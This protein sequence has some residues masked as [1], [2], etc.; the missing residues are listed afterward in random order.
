ML[1]YLV[2]TTFQESRLKDSRVCFPC[3]DSLSPFWLLPPA[4]KI[5][6]FSKKIVVIRRTRCDQLNWKWD[7]AYKMQFM[8]ECQRMHK[9]ER[10]GE[11]LTEYKRAAYRMM[12]TSFMWRDRKILVKSVSSFK[13][14]RPSPVLSSWPLQD[15]GQKWRWLQ[16]C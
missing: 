8:H 15:K 16:W 4:A 11:S 5:D 13:R 10:E 6:P 14:R 3:L 9:R 1:H 2:F 12:N 7:G